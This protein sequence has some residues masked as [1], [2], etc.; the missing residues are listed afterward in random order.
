M[1]K[2]RPRDSR[3]DYGGFGARWFFLYT[4]WEDVEVEIDDEDIVVSRRCL[5][6][7]AYWDESQ[8]RWE[9]IGG[10]FTRYLYDPLLISVAIVGDLVRGLP[11]GQNGE[12]EIVN[13]SAK[14]YLE[15]QLDYGVEGFYT[16]GDQPTLTEAV[17]TGWIGSKRRAGSEQLVG[18]EYQTEEATPSTNGLWKVR[19]DGLYRIMI[20]GHIPYSW[21]GAA[22][23]E[24]YTTTSALS[25]PNNH[26]HDVTVSAIG[27]SN[28]FFNLDLWNK[29]AAG[30]ANAAHVNALGYP[31]QIEH[32]FLGPTD[33]PVN[34]SIQVAAEWNV[35]LSKGDKFSLKC[36][37]TPENSLVV[38]FNWL[39]M[40]IEYIGAKQDWVLFD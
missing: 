6:Q 26:T 12:W 2:D 17:A 20:S 19:R 35:C 36:I 34:G 24:T 3:L 39:N 7:D 8:S 33:S 4:A 22:T 16:A 1:S 30:G 15:Y 31:Y 23:G 11:S 9:S 27:Q 21:T 32:Q 18:I 37:T 25:A 38:T 10:A 5:V 40:R 28:C 13:E 14:N 29:L